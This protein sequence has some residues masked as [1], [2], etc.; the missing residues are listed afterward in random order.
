[1]KIFLS[2]NINLIFNVINNIEIT[3]LDRNRQ[4]FISKNWKNHIDILSLINVKIKIDDIHE[5]SR[6]FIYIIIENNIKTLIK[7]TKYI[8][9]HYIYNKIT[10]YFVNWIFKTYLF[11][12]INLIIVDKKMQILSNIIKKR[13]NIIETKIITINNQRDH[14]F[15]N[16]V[17]ILT[18][19]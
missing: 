16:I 10:I 5:T 3:N 19:Y 6:K 13:K 12:I 9:K 4:I 17:D 15:I 18:L 1:M 14:R 8:K 11:Q 2:T 7:N